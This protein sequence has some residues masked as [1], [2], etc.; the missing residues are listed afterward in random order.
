MENINR[1]LQWI[2]GASKWS[3]WSQGSLKRF[4]GWNG[5]FQDDQRAALW[6]ESEISQAWNVD[7]Q[8]SP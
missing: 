6:H 1:K 7:R 4:G 5:A 2:V 3:I 8:A